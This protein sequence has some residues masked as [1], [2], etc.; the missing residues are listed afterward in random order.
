METD[1]YNKADKWSPRQAPP[2]PP[3]AP[4]LDP[5]PPTLPSH[6][7]SYAP[8]QFVLVLEQTV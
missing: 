8:T 2:P 7:A 5:F 3:P 6:V 4:A 1:I